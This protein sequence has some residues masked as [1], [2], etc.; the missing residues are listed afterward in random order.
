MH[1][2]RDNPDTCFGP[3]TQGVVLGVFFDSVEWIWA[4][5]PDKLGN[6]VL[7]LKEALEADQV[8]QRFLKSLYGKLEHIRE[9]VP[10]SKFHIGQFNHK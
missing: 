3:S 4:L 5:R 6:I 9:L 1:A 2:C 7:M 8:E 10:D